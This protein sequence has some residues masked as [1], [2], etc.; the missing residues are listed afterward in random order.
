VPEFF[1]KGYEIF[2]PDEN[3]RFSKYTLRGVLREWKDN[4]WGCDLI[5][6]NNG[7]WDACDFGDGVFTHKSEYAEN[8]LRI[9]KVLKQYSDKVVF[10]TTTPVADENEYND[11]RSIKEYNEFIVPKLKEEGIIINDLHNLVYADIDR[12]IRKDDNIHLT[13]DGIDIC[14]KRVAE[15]IKSALGD[16]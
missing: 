15:V 16:K 2:Q 1:G 5:H 3:C 4:L 10:A 8:M 7:L 12:Y 9:A 6:W 11:N 14:A 13:D